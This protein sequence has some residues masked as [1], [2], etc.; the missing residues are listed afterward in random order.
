MT[1][2]L[3]FCVLVEIPVALAPVAR[4]NHAALIETSVC[5]RPVEQLPENERRDREAGRAEAR[6]LARYM[7]RCWTV[8]V[9]ESAK[10]NPNPFICLDAVT[11]LMQF[12]TAL[13][14]LNQNPTVTEAVARVRVYRAWLFLIGRVLEPARANGLNVSATDQMLPRFLRYLDQNYKPLFARA[15]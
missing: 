10:P 7:D 4:P 2:Y 8:L 1:F 15:G 13:W 12:D 3:V 14:T 5:A 6:A 9:Y 11:V